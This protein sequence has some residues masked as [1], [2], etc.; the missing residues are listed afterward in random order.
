MGNKL[1]NYLRMSGF[2]WIMEKKD[3]EED[4]KI[5]DEIVDELTLFN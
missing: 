5:E 4:A 1:G 3:A 2:S